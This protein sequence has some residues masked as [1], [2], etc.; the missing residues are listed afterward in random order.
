[1][2][3]ALTRARARFKKAFEHRYG[4][5]DATEGASHVNA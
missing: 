2:W 1:V 4:G 3:V 5:F